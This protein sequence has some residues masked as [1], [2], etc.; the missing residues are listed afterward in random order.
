MLQDAQHTLNSSLHNSPDSAPN[1][2][3][4][5]DRRLQAAT[6]QPAPAEASKPQQT[7]KTR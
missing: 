5:S 2:R 3:R 4:R 1:A 7:A 6:N